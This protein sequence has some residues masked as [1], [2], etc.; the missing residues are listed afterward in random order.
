MKGLLEMARVPFLRRHSRW[1]DNV[2]AYLDGE[3]SE[4]ERSRFE[5][6]AAGCEGCRREL[7]A[8][9]ELKTLLSGLPE[10]AAP[11]SFRLTP[12]MVEATPVPAPPRRSQTPLRVS[13]FAAGLAV[14]AL[15]TVGVIDVTSGGSNSSTTDT[16]ASAGS[17]EG[18]AMAVPK[19]ADARAA[20][21]AGSPV[22]A[23]AAPSETKAAA[24]TSTVSP[25]PT[26]GIT[27]PTA[28]GPTG[29]SNP[30]A[31]AEASP[32]PSATSGSEASPTSSS[33][34]TPAVP[35]TGPG[36]TGDL[37]QHGFAPTETPEVGTFSAAGSA[38]ADSNPDGGAIAT[39]AY[40]RTVAAD[41]AHAWYR[42]AEFGLGAFALL[43]IA[44]S[45]VLARRRRSE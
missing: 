44:A 38:P 7:A 27:A 2:S 21:A 40:P 29:A 4:R 31:T 10:V 28:H 11:R 45:I 37:G 25:T 6:H 39:A 19:A 15:V 20:T 9:R 16:R 1:R 18:H 14:V 5:A 13:Q 24:S 42:P 35:A 12:E 30:P 26:T 23:E 33:S 17:T 43:A 22:A 3:L 36:T 8:Q 41:D 32:P 34:P